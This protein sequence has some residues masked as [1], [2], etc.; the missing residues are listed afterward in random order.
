[1][2]TLRQANTWSKLFGH[3]GYLE[4]PSVS[5]EDEYRH[6]AMI[7]AREHCGYNYATA[8]EPCGLKNICDGFHGDY[9]S[10]HGAGEAI[11]QAIPPVEDPLHYIREQWKIVED[12]DAS[13][14]ATGI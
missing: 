4:D 9:A 5:R 12:D 1:M 14:P 6:S 3:K 2:V 7:R 13:G 8:C 11:T 10:L